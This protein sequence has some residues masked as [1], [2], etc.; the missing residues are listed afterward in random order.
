MRRL[1]FCILFFG[2]VL[3]VQAQVHGVVLNIDSIPLEKVSVSYG[4]IGPTVFTDS[5]G[6]FS[7]ERRVGGTI[8]FSYVG[9]KSQ[10]VK[11]KGLTDHLVIMMKEDTHKLDEV[12]VLSE[13][14]KKIRYSRKNNP[15]VD[16][17]NRV[18]EANKSDDMTQ[19]EYYSFDRYQKITLS[20]NDITDNQLEE[21]PL[22]KKWM[23][24]YMEVS[25]LTGK[26]I[27]PISIDETVTR[28]VYRREP[29]DEKNIIMG[30][31]SDGLNELFQTGDILNQ[32]LKDVFTDVDIRC[33]YVRLF[34]YPFVS[35]IG[36]TAI[37]FYHFYIEDTVKVAGDSCYHLQ[38]IPNNPQDFGFRGE[39]YIM[40]DS[41]LKVRKCNFTIP[42]RSNVNFVKNM[43]VE[44]EYEPLSTGEW[45][46]TKDEMMVEMSLVK[47]F[48]DMMATRTTTERNHSFD[49]VENRLFRG[50][51]P[52]SH[53]ADAQIK[54]ENF[55][56][57][58]RPVKLTKTE[59]GMSAFINR[60]AQSK[61]YRWV[62]FFLKALVENYVETTP[63]YQPEKSS[64]TSDD[65]GDRT[66]ASKSKFDIGP[67]TTFIS[68]NYVDRARLS[69]AG[70][71]T[72]NL[73]PHW[74]WDG[75]YAYGTHS[76]KSYYAS[77]ITYSFNKKKYV[78]FEFPQRSISFEST[79]DV[80]AFSDK[81]LV[82]NKD[83]IF[84]SIKWQN[85]HEMFFYNRQR[86]SYIYESDW[87]LSFNNEIKTEEMKPAGSLQFLQM[88]NK[89]LN[90]K[91][92][93][94]T[95]FKASIR[96]CPGLTF[97][98]TKQQRLPVNL[99]APEFSVSHS[100]GVKG[101]L[102]GDYHSNVTELHMYKRTWFGSWGY[103]N[104]NVDASAQWNRVPFPL[105]LV[106]PV[107]TT[108]IED[109]STFGM[110]R[111]MEFMNDRQLYWSMWWDMNGKILNRIP[112]LHKLKWREHI[113]FKGIYGHLTDKNN[114]LLAENQNNKVLMRF[115]DCVNIMDK[116]KP[117]MEFEVGVHN[118]LKFFSISYVRRLN[119]HDLP[120]TK[121]N[122]VR[123]TYIL[124]F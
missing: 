43:R 39:I 17:M 2:F 123:F 25:P 107:N 84:L 3:G 37:S 21:G 119:Y 28:H 41:S 40:T 99:D 13:K 9:L 103:I 50:K 97:V 31:R 116:S 35:P 96:Y 118:I 115:P 98:T 56:N 12:V 29:K 77:N 61:N 16:L 90:V 27:M 122:G 117:Y 109:E 112:L 81:F 101:F 79:Y 86:L 18:I 113:G 44:V 100:I 62:M 83:N 120:D 47:S 76:Q 22:S 23:R 80:M 58:Y 55:W 121:K 92:L 71:T 68:S 14:K 65:S 52:E 6:S 1:V 5:Q 42:G 87:G 36:R 54:D 20:L 19:H 63:A 24:D 82:H 66:V 32:M 15:A 33:D 10:T 105:L 78:P 104:T 38:F 94:T 95:E 106:P 57:A 111:N 73:S 108:Y 60:L 48:G 34:Q 74:F 70:R 89:E 59:S 110:M 53:L 75:F 46:Q 85:P 72:A 4:R 45:V 88:E 102:G 91:S 8:T 114:P 51:S 93:R 49:K 64:S 69:F 7:I 67:V 26:R 30:Q 124:T 11:V